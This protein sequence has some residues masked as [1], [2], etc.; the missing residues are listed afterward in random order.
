[1]EPD[2][3]RMSQLGIL[4]QQIVNSLTDRNVVSNSGRVRVGKENIAIDPTGTFDSEKEIE[5]LLITGHGSDQQIYL[6]DVATVRRGYQE[7]QQKILR[8]GR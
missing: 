1:M 2:R 6:R 4:P 7:P 3:D 5:D 8:Y